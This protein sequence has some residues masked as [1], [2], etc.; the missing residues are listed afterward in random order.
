MDRAGP[1]GAVMQTIPLGGRV[2]NVP[3]SL[4][5]KLWESRTKFRAL[6]GRVVHPA[7]I[8]KTATKGQQ[9]AN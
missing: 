1:L 2:S 9:Q 5:I 8:G 6:K 7:G 4:A 3:D